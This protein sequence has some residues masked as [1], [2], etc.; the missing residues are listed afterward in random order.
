MA[1]KA[2]SDYSNGV[3]VSENGSYR[4][5]AQSGIKGVTVDWVSESITPAGTLTLSVDGD[6]GEGDNVINLGSGQR[7]RPVNTPLPFVDV[8][9]AG[10]PAGA[11]IVIYLR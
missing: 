4:F 10:L 8:D 1:R 9:V 6:V 2:F 11:N 5:G 3:Q 7:A